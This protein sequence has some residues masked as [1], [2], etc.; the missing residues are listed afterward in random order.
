M[1]EISDK[2]KLCTCKA[3]DVSLLKHY[4]RLSRPFNDDS[5]T[6]GEIIP[7]ADIG[8]HTEQ[9]NKGT[10]ARLLNSGHC[11]DVKMDMQEGDVLILYFSCRDSYLAY[12]FEYKKSKWKFFDSDPFGN[13][14]MDIKEGKI[15]RPFKRM[16]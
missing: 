13:G 12:G 10:L 9:L 16:I 5:V 6:L 2:L 7:P 4:W 8:A 14:L 15:L 1:C 11:F 3:S